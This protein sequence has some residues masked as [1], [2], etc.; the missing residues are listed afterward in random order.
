MNKIRLLALSLA[1]ATNLACA[2]APDSPPAQRV[3]GKL[4]FPTGSKSPEAQAAF[5]EGMLYL[6]LFEYRSAEDAFRRA[7]ELDPAMAM[8][9]WGEAATYIHPVWNQQ[10][11]DLGRAALAKL[12]PTP[13]GRAATARDARERGFLAV[14]EAW[15]GEGEKPARDLAALA[16]AEAL[17]KAYPKDDEAQLLLALTLLGADQGTRNLPRFLRAADIA[18]KV[19]AHN[20]KHPGAAHFWI[21]GMDDPQHAAGA[22][23]AAHA[24]SKIAPDAGHS[25]HMTSHIFVA[26]GRWQDV[27]DANLAA[28]RVIEA[29]LQAEGQPPYRCGHYTEW[30]QYAWLQQ[31]L[32]AEATKLL[33]DCEASGPPALSWMRLHPGQPFLSARTPEKLEESFRTSLDRLR[34]MALVDSPAQRA[35]L[36]AM[37]EPSDDPGS[38]DPGYWFAKGLAQLQSG[39]AAEAGG[40][41]QVLRQMSRPATPLPENEGKLVRIMAQML[42]GS[43]DAQAGRADEAWRKLAGAADAFDELPVDYGPP[44]TVKPP[45]ELLAEFLLAQGRTA[46]A[47][48]EFERALKSTPQRAAAV[49]GLERSRA[50]KP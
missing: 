18:K 21:H 20:P 3:L 29:N 41:L 38:T 42:D 49:R 45:R 44:T 48:R 7:Q 40:S 1:L 24:L 25:Q 22:L 28:N 47:I 9:Y 37:P 16:A 10:D 5:T 6:H 31:G 32:E 8:A 15:Y 4:S 14:A 23:V 50:A 35:G 34:A 46:E 39:K 33:A 13:A 26:L 19:Y 43:L 30:L 11:M 27:V 2:H 12:A 36:L 17:A